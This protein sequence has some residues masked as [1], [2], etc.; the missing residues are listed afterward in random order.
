MIANLLMMASP[1]GGA[2][3]MGTL[4]MLAAFFAILYFLLIRPQRQQQKAHQELVARLRRG[5]EVVT[6][7]GIVGKIIHEEGDRLT[8]KTANDTRLEIERSKV[9]RV[10]EGSE[11]S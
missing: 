11:A 2:N 1:E 5:D 3:P 4:F 6:I 8:I 7:G 10:L 9:A